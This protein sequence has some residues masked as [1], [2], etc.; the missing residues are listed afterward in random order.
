MGRHELLV[1]VEG[2]FRNSEGLI[3][4]KITKGLIDM[5]V[6]T[7]WERIYM[8]KAPNAVSWYWWQARQLA[9]LQHLQRPWPRFCWRSNCCYSSGGHAR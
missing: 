6:Q 1:A 4:R 8:E 9:C 2:P 3:L 5:S 7:H